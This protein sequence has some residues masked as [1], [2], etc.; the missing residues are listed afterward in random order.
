MTYP[1]IVLVMAILLTTVM[2]IFIVPVFEQMFIDL[3]GELPL[4]TRCW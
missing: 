3:G 1:V 2:L 4:L